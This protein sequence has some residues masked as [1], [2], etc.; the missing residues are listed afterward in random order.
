[1]KEIGLQES[2]QIQLEILSYVD[3]ICKQYHIRYSLYGGTLIGAIRH[4]GFIP[5]DDDIDIIVPREDYKKLIE[6]FD[7]SNGT[8]IL[9]S[10]EN[11]CKYEYPYA[12]IEDSRTLLIEK[13]TTRDYGVAID[14]FPCD[15]VGDT[16]EQA[17]EFIRKRELARLLFL[18]K[19]VT[20]SKRNKVIKRV[21]MILLKCLLAFIPIRCLASFRSELAQSKKER[22]LL[23]A[24]VVLISNYGIKE[25]IP[26]KLFD[27]LVD[28]EFEGKTF[29]AFEDYKTYLSSVFGDYMKLP[30]VEKRVSPHLINKVFWK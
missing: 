14:V 11:D 19:L 18:A 13:T 2:K 30:P 8:Y 28:V 6:V 3:K 24:D 21:Y 9:H 17:I 22:T 5:W 15:Y 7:N 27:K 26:T 10:L 20:P 12:K 25:I 16:K 1:M 23:S 29:C 4:K